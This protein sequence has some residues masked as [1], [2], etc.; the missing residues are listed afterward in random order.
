MAV[1]AAVKI[2]LNWQLAALPELGILGAGWATIADISLA[3]LLNMFF[4]WRGTG[5]FL[6]AKQLARVALATA[7]MAAAMLLS[8]RAAGHV[9]VWGMLL[10]FGV[11]AA[12]YIPCALFLGALP[13]KDISQIP[14]FG[15]FYEKRLKQAAHK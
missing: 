5:Y 1:A 15:E 10:A 11:G 8:L 3:A 6:E 9:G 12:T 2:L 14:V 7:A 4:I 13:T